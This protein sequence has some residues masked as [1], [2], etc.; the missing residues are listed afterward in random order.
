[1]A[2][3]SLVIWASDPPGPDRV[4]VSELK[5]N[6][7]Q[8]YL[9]EGTTLQSAI[10]NLQSPQFPLEIKTS[11]LGHEN[12]EESKRGREEKEINLKVPMKRKFGL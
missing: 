12:V 5:F 7:P 4:K 3:V 11:F 2:D 1:M 10:C 6:L 9:D 8:P